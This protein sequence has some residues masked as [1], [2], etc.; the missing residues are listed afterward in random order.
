MTQV[1]QMLTEQVTRNE[2]SMTLFQN[3]SISMEQLLSSVHNHASVSQDLNR[4]VVSISGD[5]HSMA[6]QVREHVS[7]LGQVVAMSEQAMDLTDTN[8]QRTE[9]LSSLIS[10]LARYA[11]YLGED[12]RKLGTE[13]LS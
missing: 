8:L 4:T 12:F 7:T 10:D 2:Q 3:I 1:G 9:D 5:F 13:E 11:L 6:N